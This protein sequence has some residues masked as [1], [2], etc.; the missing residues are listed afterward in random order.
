MIYRLV[1]KKLSCLYSQVIEVL[2]CKNS[3]VLIMK[4][5]EIN[6]RLLTT[7]QRLVQ[8]GGG[9]WRALTPS[10]ENTGITTNWWTIIKRKTLELTK[11]DTPHPKTKEKPQWDVRRGKITI[12]WNPIIA[13]WVNHK[14]ENTYTK[15]VHLL[16]WRFWAPRQASKPG[17]WAIAGGI[18]RK[19]DI[20]SK[21]D[22][23]AGLQQDW[24]KQRL[25]SWRAHTK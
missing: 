21:Q 18:P 6:K 16:E 25:H 23:I 15:E 3:K 7:S 24:G 14:L 20:E 22:L 2:L 8:D 5:L 1:K 17:G 11:R 4:L 9:E 12:K 10:C 19:S 13:G